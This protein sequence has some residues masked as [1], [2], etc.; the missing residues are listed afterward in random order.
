MTLSTWERQQWVCWSTCHNKWRSPFDWCVLL[1][2]RPS[3]LEWKVH[4]VKKNNTK[5]CKM[6]FSEKNKV[7]IHLSWVLL[8]SVSSWRYCFTFLH[9]K[10]C[11]L[12]GFDET[13]LL[14]VENL[15]TV[16][17]LIL[18][19]M[20][21]CEFLRKF[22]QELLQRNKRQDEEETANFTLNAWNILLLGMGGNLADTTK[23][24]LFF[25]KHDY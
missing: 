19:L 3:P 23:H 22:R 21:K 5:T 16:H 18:L 2:S 14:F 6:F 12:F 4:L 11:Q 10:L 25:C 9:H 17:G 20:W 15:E 24:R 1:A 7:W 13:S 8:A